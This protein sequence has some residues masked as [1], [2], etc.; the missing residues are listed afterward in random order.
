MAGEHLTGETSMRVKWNRLCNEANNAA[1]F[2]PQPTHISPEK[3]PLS[4]LHRRQPIGY[5]SMPQCVL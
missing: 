2:V 4:R 3:I 5:C 1:V